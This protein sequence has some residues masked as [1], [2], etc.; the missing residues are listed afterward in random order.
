MPGYEHAK[1]SDAKFSE[2][3]EHASAVQVAYLPP[4]SGLTDRE[5]LK[6]TGEIGFL[7]GQG[8]TAEVL[9]NLCYQVHQR[10]DKSA[11]E[12]IV[13]ELLLQRGCADGICSRRAA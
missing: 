1:V 12:D 5:H 4:M 9:R 7:I 10:D 13:G 2:I 8:R 6:Q 11:W 3:P